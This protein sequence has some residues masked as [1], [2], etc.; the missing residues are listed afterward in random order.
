VVDDKKIPFYLLLVAVARNHPFEPAILF[1]YDECT[2]LIDIYG[3]SFK[4]VLKRL[5]L[6][7]V[8]KRARQALPLL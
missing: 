4:G 1:S 2:E 3:L 5:D 7:M 8:L 6:H